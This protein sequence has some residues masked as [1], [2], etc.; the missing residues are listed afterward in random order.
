[1]YR[2]QFGLPDCTTA[3]GCFKKVDQNGGTSYPT[4]NSAWAQEISL[5]LD[6]ASAIC[7]NCKIVLVEAD[8][9]SFSDLAAAVD[10]AVAQG[11]T[12]V[13]NSYGNGEF[14]GEDTYE[15][16][17]NHSGVAVTV[18]SGDSG[19]GAEFPASS[20]YMTAVGGT[21]L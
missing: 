20:Q 3:N 14:K 16:H 9:S 2:S 19:Y 6:M 13:S 21:T 17:Y 5:D 4:P 12:Q 15:S 18:S 1:P 11:A 7:P 8:S 10:E